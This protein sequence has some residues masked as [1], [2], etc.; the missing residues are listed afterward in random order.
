MSTIQIGELVVLR[1]Q[2]LL[3]AGTLMFA[4]IVFH[5]TATGNDWNKVLSAPVFRFLH[6]EQDSVQRWNLPL[7]CAAILCVALSQPVVRQAEDETWRHSIGWI[8]VVDVSRSMTLE[9]VV[10][11]RL[12]AARQALAVLSRESSA[13]PLAMIIYS[14]DAYLAAPPAFDKSVFNEHAALLAHGV[15]PAEGSNLARALSLAS[16]VITDSQFVAARVFVLSDSGG[17]SGGAMAAAAFLR[18][19][20]H[21]LDT[22]VFGNSNNQAQSDQ[23]LE[24][25]LHLQDALSLAEAGGGISIQTD[26][27]GVLDYEMLQLHEQSSASTTSDL[28]ALVWQD[29]SHWL[30]IVSIPLFLLLFVRETRV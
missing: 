29:Q 26:H 4:A 27:F 6:G 8:A 25:G 10:P 22:L 16:S 5:R 28:H 19:E 7:W 2:W 17:I 11:Y 13:R 24:T 3:L 12:S 1:P 15:I 21:R 20:G 14:G 23:N 9:D 18:S 30:L